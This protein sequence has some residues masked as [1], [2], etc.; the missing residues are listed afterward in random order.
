MTTALSSCVLAVSVALALLPGEARAGETWLAVAAGWG[1]GIEANAD[2]DK[3]ELR[4][5]LERRFSPALSAGLELAGV[6]FSGSR[7]GV[8]VRT[9]GLT[10]LP[11]ARWHFLRFGGSSVAF[12]FGFGG[13]RFASAFPPGGTRWNGYSAFGLSL[14][15]AAGSGLAFTGGVRFLHHSNG[16]GLV[17]ENP[18]YDGVSLHAGVAFG[19]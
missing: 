1:T 10:A 14:T 11:V 6:R 8:G 5:G 13:A 3:L 19:R 9:L 16:R 15:A 2:L 4:L 12:E 17:T 18:A 7:D